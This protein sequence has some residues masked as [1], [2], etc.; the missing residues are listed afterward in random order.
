MCVLRDHIHNRPV[1][2]V[3]DA[4]VPV[5]VGTQGLAAANKAGVGVH[6]LTHHTAVMTITATI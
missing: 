5:L 2:V 4:V 1:G 6:H 3:A